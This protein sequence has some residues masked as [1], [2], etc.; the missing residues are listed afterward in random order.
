[1][2][3]VRRLYYAVGKLLGVKVET[4]NF[5]RPGG[6]D[7]PL[8]RFIPDKEIRIMH[9]TER[10]DRDTGLSVAS[11]RLEAAGAPELRVVERFDDA[12]RKAHELTELCNNFPAFEVR[13]F[14]E[15]YLSGEL[16]LGMFHR[17]GDVTDGGFVISALHP[18]RSDGLKI[19]HFG[20]VEEVMGANIY[21]Q[22][23]CVFSNDVK[24]M[25]GENKPISS[26][27]RF[28]AF[29]DAS[30]SIRERLY[31]FGTLV[32]TCEEQFFTLRDREVC[33]INKVLAVTVSKNDRENVEAA[34]NGVDVSASLHLERQRQRGFLDRYNE[35]VSGI[36]WHLFDDHIHV[37]VEPATKP[38]LKDWE[39]G[40]GPIDR[41]L[42]V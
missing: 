21:F 28:Q 22:E 1:M 30:L 23:P 6:R 27:V 36:S 31:E 38:L 9:L 13:G 20:V 37:V 41:G 16:K 2:S 5:F 32:T 19:A 29:D 18:T 35:V 26:V 33:V 12:V 4:K 3:E 10:R 7:N 40:F 42:C 39:L 14:V 34:S 11:E 15:A 24:V 17:L 25:E 8:K